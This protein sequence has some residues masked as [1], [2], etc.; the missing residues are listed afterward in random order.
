MVLLKTRRKNIRWIGLLILPKTTHM[1][2]RGSQTL[3]RLLTPHLDYLP[4]RTLF[5]VSRHYIF[6]LP[7]HFDYLFEHQYHCFLLILLLLVQILEQWRHNYFLGRISTPVIPSQRIMVATVMRLCWTQ[8]LK[9][10][11]GI[12]GMWMDGIVQIIW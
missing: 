11:L 7:V 9:I 10:G 4:T 12:K 1:L 2:L 8:C 6:W 3:R 5:I